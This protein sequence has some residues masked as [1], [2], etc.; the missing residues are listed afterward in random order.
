MATD[1]ALKLALAPLLAAQGLAVRRRALVLPEAAG[2]REGVAGN[3]GGFAPLRLLI[4]GDSSAAGVGAATQDEALSGQLLRALA[5]HRPIV[6]RLIARTGDTTARALA[7]LEAA[8]AAR[9]D[10]AITALGV[11][12]VT[13]G[14]PLRRFLAGQAALRRVLHGRFGVAHVLISGLPPMHAFPLLPQPLRGVLGI[15]A[16][17]FDRALAASVAG[18]DDAT[19]LPFNL[20]LTP[21]LM[22]A[23]GFH[24]GPKGY[25]IWAGLLAEEVLRRAPAP[26][27]RAARDFPTT[28][29]EN[30]ANT[31]Q[32]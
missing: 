1:T 12:D 2:P 3:V 20:P 25:A 19:H 8:P 18:R 5:P 13:H 10:I 22:A 32:G 11:N 23:D 26:Q 21:E 30:A 29:R 14:V 16:R 15:T 17:R 9:F 4:V 27:G 6:W 31:R 28:C 7:R 24:P